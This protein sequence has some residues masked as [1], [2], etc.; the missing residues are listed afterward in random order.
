MLEDI[1]MKPQTKFQ[2]AVKREKNHLEDMGYSESTLRSWMYGM[3]RPN[4]RHALVLGTLL[5]MDIKTILHSKIVN[6]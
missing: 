2:L 3:R 6:D 1:I 4:Y 5:K